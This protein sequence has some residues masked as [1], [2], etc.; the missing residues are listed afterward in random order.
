MNYQNLCGIVSSGINPVVTFKK[1]MEEYEC[2]PEKGMRARIIQA[3]DEKDNTIKFT[4]DFSEFDEFNKQFES[5]TYYGKDG[6]DKLIT[7]REANYYT[8]KDDIFFTPSDKIGKDMVIEETENLS[9]Y[10]QFKAEK[11]QV[12]YV[13]WLENK[14]I[15]SVAKEKRLKELVKS[16][17]DRAEDNPKGIQA[18]TLKMFSDEL[19]SI[20]NWAD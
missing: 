17:L 9:L 20:I 11:S 7:A 14:A 4:F 13:K 8:V 12:S 10:D 2:Y 19:R 1:G 16:M 18:G 5:A 15:Q 3:L 6:S